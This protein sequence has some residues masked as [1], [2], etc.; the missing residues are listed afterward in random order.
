[1]S[2]K[3]GQGQPGWVRRTAFSV[4]GVVGSGALSGLIGPRL[5][6]LQPSAATSELLRGA[7]PIGRRMPNV[8]MPDGRRLFEL[9]GPRGLLL[10]HCSEDVP[11]APDGVTVAA[12]PAGLPRP[13]AAHDRLLIRPDYLVALAGGREDVAETEILRALGASVAAIGSSEP[14]QQS[15]AANR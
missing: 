15:A 14:G 3:Q 12:L 4:I 1:V 13:F 10:H 2:T 8:V 6:M 7:E 5:S 9:I 11:T